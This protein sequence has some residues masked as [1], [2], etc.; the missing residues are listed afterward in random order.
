MCKR[1]RDWAREWVSERLPSGRYAW[2]TMKWI[3]CSIRMLS[4]A[5]FEQPPFVC[6]E[7]Y[8]HSAVI[9]CLIRT[10]HNAISN[11]RRKKHKMNA[12]YSQSIFSDSYVKFLREYD[13]TSATSL[14]LSLS[15]SAPWPLCAVFSMRHC[16]NVNWIEIECKG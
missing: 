13:K 3:V 5:F 6:A 9:L 8:M 15:W 2:K 1:A 10:P 4:P 14:S 12:V 16:W 11:A 7:G